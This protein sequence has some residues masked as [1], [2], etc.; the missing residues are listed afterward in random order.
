MRR[1]PAN[2]SGQSTCVRLFLT[3]IGVTQGCVEGPAS[4]FAESRS[5]RLH[6]YRTTALLQRAACAAVRTLDCRPVLSP[7]LWST[8]LQGR[9]ALMS[10][11]AGPNIAWQR[12]GQRLCKQPPCTTHTPEVCTQSL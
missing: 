7:S 6:A 4:E 12:R 3:Q 9:E 10:G 8:Q 5:S 11:T 2:V 1:T